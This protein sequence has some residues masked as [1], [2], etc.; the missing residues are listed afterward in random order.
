MFSHQQGPGAWG[1]QPLL[2]Q[3]L[4]SPAAGTGRPEP[5]PQGTPV[6]ARKESDDQGGREN[7]YVACQTERVSKTAK[8]CPRGS[9]RQIQCFSKPSAVVTVITGR[10]LRTQRPPCAASAPAAPH[11]DFTHHVAQPHAISSGRRHPATAAP[12]SL[13]SRPRSAPRDPTFPDP[14]R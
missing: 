4:P 2:G 7:A 5:C 11:V 3:Q 6:L 14:P 12:P 10:P 13:P 1:L 9:V 8:S